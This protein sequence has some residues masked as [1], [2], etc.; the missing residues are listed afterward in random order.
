[1]FDMLNNLINIPAA[2]SRLEMG[3][4]ISNRRTRI[5]VGN[6][7]S[8]FPPYGHKRQSTSQ[9]RQNKFSQSHKTRLKFFVGNDIFFSLTAAIGSSGT[10]FLPPNRAGSVVAAIPARCVP[11]CAS[12]SSDSGKVVVYLHGSAVPTPGALGLLLAARCYF[13][14]FGFYCGGGCAPVHQTGNPRKAPAAPFFQFMIVTPN[15]RHTH[16]YGTDLNKRLPGRRLFTSFKDLDL[17]ISRNKLSPVLTVFIKRLTDII[18]YGLNMETA[19]AAGGMPLY[20]TGSPDCACPSIF[21]CPGMTFSFLTLID[22]LGPRVCANFSGIIPH[23]LGDSASIHL[24]GFCFF[25]KII[26][27]GT[28]SKPFPGITEFTIL[29]KHPATAPCHPYALRHPRRDHTKTIPTVNS[30]SI[31]SR[32]TTKK[33]LHFRCRHFAGI[34]FY[35]NHKKLFCI[36]YSLIKVYR[37]NV[38]PGTAFALSRPEHVHLKKFFATDLHGQNRTTRIKDRKD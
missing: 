34:G 23:T 35:M 3:A 11:G 20:P 30:T 12:S 14:I 15:I 6:K 17:K 10:R 32:F 18:L 2:R 16:L 27:P 22:L 36:I 21:T 7:Q 29:I 37:S 1:M 38:V 31:P 9:V 28:S 5:L 8:H 4:T 26:N 24:L 33:L 25:S 13:F 19:R